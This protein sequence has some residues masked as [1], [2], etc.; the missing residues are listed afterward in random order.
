MKVASPQRI[1]LIIDKAKANRLPR[2]RIETT[3]T[4]TERVEFD[5]GDE[6]PTAPAED[7]TDADTFMARRAAK[8]STL[9]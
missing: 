6:V 4:M 8:R 5:L 2:I 9:K 7:P 3:V 1:Q